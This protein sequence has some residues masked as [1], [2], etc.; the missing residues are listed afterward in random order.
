MSSLLRNMVN[1]LKQNFYGNNFL[2]YY[3]TSVDK[4]IP[5]PFIIHS[6]GVLDINIQDDVKAN[7]IDGFSDVF[8]GQTGSDVDVIESTFLGGNRRIV[9]LSENMV[10][11]LE[12]WI[13]H[14]KGET[15]SKFTITVAPLMQKS[16]Y[17]L[18]NVNILPYNIAGFSDKAPSSDGY[19]C[20]DSTN[21]Y[22]TLWAFKTPMTVKYYSLE[23]R[24]YKYLTILS[25][26]S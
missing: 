3:D 6:N 23:S 9:S 2:S 20:G 10:I 25:W 11:F 1:T 13:F 19:V 18:N 4:T 14:E 21:N 8:Y 22:R 5:V 17:I 15:A 12:N 24:K 16:Q 7:L 26:V